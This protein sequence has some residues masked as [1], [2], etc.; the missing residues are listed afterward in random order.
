MSTSTVMKKSG[1]LLLLLLQLQASCAQKDVWR[2]VVVEKDMVFD[3]PNEGQLHN[4]VGDQEANQEISASLIVNRDSLR[5]IKYANARMIGDTLRILISQTTP[6]YHHT[7][8]IYVSGDKYRIDY[9]FLTS[10]EPTERIIRTVQSKLM[11]SSL[12]FVAGSE[13]RGHAEFFGKCT[14]GCWEKI[15]KVQ[16]NFKAVIE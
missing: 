8:A 4:D 3:I 9:T 16:G 14:K 10:G 15:L 5:T 6:A 11:L 1:I 2:R 13:I 7:F 12:N